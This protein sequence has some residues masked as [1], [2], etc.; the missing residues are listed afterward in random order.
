MR[1][2]IT[3][4]LHRHNYLEVGLIVQSLHCRVDALSTDIEQSD[5]EVIQTREDG[6]GI[7]DAT[8]RHRRQLLIMT[9]IICWLGVE[10]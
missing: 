7:W 9:C 1:M 8:I 2:D 3:T 10:Q 5:S 4:P 6:Y